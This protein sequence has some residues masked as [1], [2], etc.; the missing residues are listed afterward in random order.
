MRMWMVDPA[1]MCRQHL[2]GEH[3]EIHML[4]GTL[5]RKRSVAGFVENNLIEFHS[6]RERHATLVREMRRRG[7]NH[8]SPL[9]RFRSRRLGEVDPRANLLELARRCKHC[10]KLQTF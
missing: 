9:P 6:I 3:V 8:R 2:L 7:M 5:K 10:R 1:L 4:V